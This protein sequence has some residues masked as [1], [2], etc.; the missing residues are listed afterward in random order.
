MNVLVI[1]ADQLRRDHLGFGGNDIVRTPNLDRLAARSQNFAQAFVTNPVCMPNRASIMTGRWPSAHG[2]R[3]NGLPLDPHVP[4]F[5]RELKDAGYRTSAIGKIH[6]QPMG[7][8]FEDFQLDEIKKAMPELWD[9]AVAGPY[10]EEFQSWEDFRL[11]RDGNVRM[12][13]DYYGFDDVELTVGHG[14]QQAGAYVSWARERGWDPAAQSGAAN[15]LET[16]PGW[17]QIYASAVPASLHPNTFIAEQSI[18]RLRQYA[19]AGQSFVMQVSFPDPHHPFAPPAE[20]FHRHSPTNMPLPRTFHDPLESAPA[21][22]QQIAGDRG[23]PGQ[24]WTLIWAPTDEQYRH[25][26]AAEL[27]SV[28][29]LDDV[30]GGILQELDQLGLSEDTLVIFTSDHGDVFGDHG[31]ML[32]HFTHYEGVLRVPLLLAVPQVPGEIH[33]ELVSSADI[34]ATVT[35][36]CLDAAMPGAQGRSLSC[37]WTDEQRPWRQALLIEED[38][39]FAMPGLS[40]P[41]RIRTV[42]TPDLRYTRILNEPCDE[43]FD[44]IRDADE[45]RNL[46]G[47]DEAA[48]LESQA[49]RALATELMRIDDDSR[50][51][52]DAA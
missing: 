27:G 19:Q 9:R 33:H 22:I 12:P 31:L 1:I 38:Q 47:L 25:A 18:A 8:P 51:P 49:N 4:T 44:R 34:A 32:K 2:L 46:A 29:F 14:D 26:L 6:L 23:K 13:S 30:I 16:F 21:H 35:D 20:Y 15:A 11:H 39:P 42:L 28:E 52:Y 50:I 5:V 40:V 10:G 48:A 36:L 45:L 24:D 7:Y 41:V 37:L 3:T 43:L 17:N